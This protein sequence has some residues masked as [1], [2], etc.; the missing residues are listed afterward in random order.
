MEVE[1]SGA[2]RRTRWI[3]AAVLSSESRLVVKPYNDAV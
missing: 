3:R 1:L 2:D